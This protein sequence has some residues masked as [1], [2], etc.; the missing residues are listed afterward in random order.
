MNFKSLWF[1][2]AVMGAHNRYR[3]EV[4]AYEALYGTGA[5]VVALAP[6]EGGVG[7]KEFD[8]DDV[9]RWRGDRNVL[10]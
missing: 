9:E 4:L 7:L 3:G 6:T 10:A 8:E 2:S 5:A 1:W